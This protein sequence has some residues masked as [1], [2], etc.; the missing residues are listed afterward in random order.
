MVPNAAPHCEV[1]GHV[2]WAFKATTAVPAPATAGGRMRQTSNGPI[3]RSFTNR[4]LT[5][6]PSGDRSSRQHHYLSPPHQLAF[7]QRRG[8]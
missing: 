5:N 2:Y 7:A 1:A 8:P 3:A 4:A 6:A